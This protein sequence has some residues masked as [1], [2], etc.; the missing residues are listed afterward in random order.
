MKP[1]I[2]VSGH[3]GVVKGNIEDEFNKFL[4]KI[5]ERE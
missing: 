1:K 5:D 2:V 4:G 3:R